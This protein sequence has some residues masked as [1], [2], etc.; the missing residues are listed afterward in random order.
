LNNKVL[1]IGLDGA[2]FDLIKPWIEEGKLPNLNRIIS[3]GSHGKLESTPFPN[4]APAWVSCMT[5]VNPGK[6]GIFG[7]GVRLNNQYELQLA[8]SSYIHTKTLPEI[9][10]EYNK[11]SIVI[12]VPI[13]YPPQKINGIVVTGMET[14]GKNSQFTHPPEFKQELEKIVPE[15][16]IEVPH[17]HYLSYGMYGKQKLVEAYLYA[18]QQREKLVLEMMKEKEW[19]FFM[20][21]F[22]SLDR[23]QHYFWGDMD[24]NHPL[25]NK[26]TPDILKEAVFK[27]YKRLDDSVGKMIDALPEENNF[28]IFIVSDHGFGSQY[29][30]FYINRWLKQK[31]FL[32]LKEENQS[33]LK[34]EINNIRSLIQKSSYYRFLVDAIMKILFKYFPKDL[35]DPGIWRQK[36]VKGFSP[37]EL[38]DWNKTKAFAEEYGIRI[39]L[40]GREPNGIVEPGDEYNE[41]VETL[42]NSLANEKHKQ[43]GAH[44][45]YKVL[46]RE[47]VYKGP[48]LERA[49]DIITFRKIGNNHLAVSG[50]KVWG[51]SSNTSGS[52][53][54]DGIMIV[55]GSGVVSDNP[56]NNAIIYDIAPSV[57]ACL[58]IPIPE[59]MDGQILAVFKKEHIESITTKKIG[60]IYK[61]AKGAE[62]YNDSEREQLEQQLKNLGYF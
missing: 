4:S 60:S 35:T 8:N 10:S 27:I 6:H 24:E 7:F 25:F 14:P 20:V 52:H 38:I 50:D 32:T 41:L 5:G 30:L 46:R 31:G 37:A 19:D 13:S 54:K 56:V 62:A 28:N 59:D 3:S 1:V 55:W 16:I 49:P 43:T 26:K 57:L 33:F 11:K 48:M 21:V 34:M 36:R 45:Y 29:E 58:G 39:N 17:Y 23:T 61:N 18:I 53:H 51:F 47:K 22:S 40:K 9:L 15:Y 42:C 12:N 44:A 2:T